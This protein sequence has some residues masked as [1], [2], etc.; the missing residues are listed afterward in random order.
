MA[1]VVTDYINRWYNLIYDNKSQTLT[2]LY[3]NSL[4]CRDYS[5]IIN[6]DDFIINTLTHYIISKYMYQ[7]SY[8]YDSKE[9]R[10][11][12]QVLYNYIISM[13]ND[14]HLYGNDDHQYYYGNYK[15]T[16]PN[17]KVYSIIPCSTIKLYESTN[18]SYN[19]VSNA[20]NGLLHQPSIVLQPVNTDHMYNSIDLKFLPNCIRDII[21]EYS[22]D[23]VYTF[24]KM[25][26]DLSE[27]IIRNESKTEIGSQPIVPAE[28]ELYKSI[29]YNSI[30]A[31]CRYVVTD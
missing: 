29:S 23:I 25:M 15:Y 12:K 7:P 16:D 28:I 27:N 30:S 2:P 1:N 22:Q 26:L 17:I 21:H 3:F 8:Y 4:Q 13:T 9:Y 14:Y 10:I 20:L 11:Y 19:I 5:L 18:D 24:I 6:P 31:Y